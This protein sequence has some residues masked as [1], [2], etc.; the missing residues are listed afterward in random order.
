M[1]RPP[2]YLAMA[3]R[4]VAITEGEAHTIALALRSAVTPPRPMDEILE[5]VP[6]ATETDKIERIGISR[7]GFYNWKLGRSRPR[8][9]QARKLARLTGL[10]IE[11]I[12]G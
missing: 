10:P 7:Q 11:E 12:L 5:L 3:E 6:G 4:L 1:V 8:R 2:D 9:D